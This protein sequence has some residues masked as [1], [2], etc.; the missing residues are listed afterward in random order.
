MGKGKGK[1]VNLLMVQPIGSNAFCSMLM[2]KDMGSTCIFSSY[3]GEILDQEKKVRS[4]SS[5]SSLAA[6]AEESH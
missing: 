5:E 4:V 1:K 2:G 3:P 6:G